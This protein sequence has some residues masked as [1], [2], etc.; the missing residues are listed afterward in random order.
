MHFSVALGDF[1]AVRKLLMYRASAKTRNSQG[2]TPFFL[3]CV[4][5]SRLMIQILLE[6]DADPSLQGIYGV[7][8]RIVSYVFILL[9]FTISNNWCV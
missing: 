7:C 8:H 1:A 9:L 2:K 3:A 4:T 5:G 6:A